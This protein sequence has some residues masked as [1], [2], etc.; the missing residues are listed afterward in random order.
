MT[1]KVKMNPKKM[2][3]VRF[4]T[5]TDQMNFQNMMIDAREKSGLAISIKGTDDRELRKPK[6]MPPQKLTPEMMA[7]LQK[8]GMP[9]VPSGKEPQLVKPEDV[10]INVEEKPKQDPARKS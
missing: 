6:Q 7:Q 10:K 3:V 5:P 9:P 2:A 8:Q 1:I 4:T